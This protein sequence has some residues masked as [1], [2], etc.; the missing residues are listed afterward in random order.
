MKAALAAMV[1]AEGGLHARLAAT[2]LPYAARL[3]WAPLLLDHGVRA[4]TSRA[5]RPW[6]PVPCRA[7]LGVAHGCGAAPAS[8]PV[9][10]SFGF[11]SLAAPSRGGRALLLISSQ[12]YVPIC[13]GLEDFYTRCLYLR[14]Q[15]RRLPQFPEQ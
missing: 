1:L 3:A 13:L 15:E 12:G 2:L 10:G 7:R 9:G 14:I 8:S 5:A 4:R 11:V 6:P